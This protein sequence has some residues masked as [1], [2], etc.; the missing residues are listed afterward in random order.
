[1][2]GQ[3]G[4]DSDPVFLRS[5]SA[6]TAAQ[7]HE[8]HFPWQD[9][10]VDCSHFQRSIF[11]LQATYNAELIVLQYDSIFSAHLRD[12]ISRLQSVPVHSG[13]HLAPLLYLLVED[14][15][16]AMAAEIYLILRNG[17]DLVPPA[18]RDSDVPRHKFSNYPDALRRPDV[19]DS[20]LGRLVSKGY[21][22]SWE[23]IR[24]E[25]GR[26]EL[27]E[28][29]YIMPINLLSK[30]NPNGSA[31][32]RLIFDPSRPDGESLNDFCSEDI[33]T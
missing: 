3:C 23:V 30:T 20:E 6:F 9:W 13:W 26:T 10:V 8:S 12:N 32:H 1:M 4:Y 22:A 24:E 18:T 15:D 7:A 25:C 29:F 33:Y 27:S 5:F 16:Q 14:S 2:I 11:D 21:V 17:Y 28:P 19:I 31:K